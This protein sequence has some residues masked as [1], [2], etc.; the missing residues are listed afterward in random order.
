MAMKSAANATQRYLDLL[1]EEG[2]RPKLEGSSDSQATIS[3]KSEGESFLLFVDEDD[4]TFLHIGSFYELGEVD[5]DC[6]LSLANDLNELLK[7]VK[8]T[9]APEDRAVRF[10]VES[11]LEDAPSMK[12]I[13]RAVSLLRGAAVEF[14]EPGR[15]VDYLDA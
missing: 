15:A 7:A 2:C 6:A 13:E 10:H 5:A 12:H 9:I 4:E 8:V 14:F 3:F 11:F 1:A